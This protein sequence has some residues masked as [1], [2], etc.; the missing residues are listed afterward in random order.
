MND[1]E[2]NRLLRLTFLFEHS[3]EL[4]NE[5]VDAILS[6]SEEC[7]PEM[8]ARIQKRFIEKLFQEKHPNPIKSIN[9]KLTF[10]AWLER[11][12][13]DARLTRSAVTQALQCE[14]NI[15]DGLAKSKLQPWECDHKLIVDLMSLFRAHYEL[16][17]QLVSTSASV[18]QISGTGS[19]LARSHG[20]KM[21]QDRGD[22]TTRAL[23]LFLAN[24]ARTSSMPIEAEHW[25]NSLEVSLKEKDLIYLIN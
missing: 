1:R 23:E 8:M 7:S 15:L 2:T 25:L 13:K 17:K 22:A 19:V 5:I 24:N 20:G 11:I 21:T 18:N 3:N 14:E 16:I 6:D 4:S 12:M 10:G 9:H